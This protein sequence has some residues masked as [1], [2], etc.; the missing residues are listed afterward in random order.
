MRLRLALLACLL[1]APALAQPADL[2]LRGGNIITVDQSWHVAQAVAVRNGRFVAIGDDATV[3]HYVGPNTQIVELAGK[4][5][6]PGLIDSHLHQLFA[7]LNGPAVQLLGAKTV[8]DVQ[9]AIGERVARPDPGQGVMAFS[10]RHGSIH[11]ERR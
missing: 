7:A 5:V 2:V 9:A 10:G 8:A 1:A 3:A 6:V 4:T 11:E